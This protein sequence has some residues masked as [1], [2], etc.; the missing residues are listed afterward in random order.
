VCCETNVYRLRI[1]DYGFKPVQIKCYD[2][3]E[4]IIV[5]YVQGKD[6]LFDLI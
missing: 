4:E 6:C 5:L 3:M 2:F 1:S